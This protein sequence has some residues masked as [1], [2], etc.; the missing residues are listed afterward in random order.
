MFP[1]SAP[2]GRR[3]TLRDVA[4]LAGVSFKTVSR[5]VNAEAGVSPQMAERVQHA[6]D[7]LGYRP[8]PAASSLRRADG[9]TKT[10]AIILEDLANPFSAALHSA[11]VAAVRARGVL[12]LA[13][14][15]DEE[16]DDE[17]EAFLAF[18]DRRVD[19]II[20]MPTSADHAWMSAPH[21][22]ER[23]VVMVDRPAAGFAA[24]VVTADHR[25]GA[26]KATAHLA[27]HGHERIAFLGDLPAIYTAGERLAGYH[28]GLAGAG[29]PRDERLE[30]TGLRDSDQARQA[31]VELLSAGAP[32]TAIF[33]AQN[34]LTV[35]AIRALRELD[36]HRQVALVG[37]DDVELAD[38]LEPGVT[39]I[40]Q[41]PAD[42]GRLAAE[43][44]LRRLDGETGPPRRHELGTRLVERGSGEIASRS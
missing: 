5:V 41:S 22:G 29:L 32:P 9:R 40:A 14:S 20:L 18:A 16:P 34:L 23:H 38:L 33:A 6:I 42:I 25:G 35:G 3:P 44:L 12:V 10:I 15:S 43:Q 24:D 36:L 17:R 21:F 26:L 7:E 4:Q 8:D 30:R 39:V 11:V 31:V 37:F 1:T 28:D 13:A 27:R 19:G 2:P